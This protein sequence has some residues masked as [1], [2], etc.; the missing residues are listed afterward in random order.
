MTSLGLEGFNSALRGAEPRGVGLVVPFPDVIFFRTVSLGSCTLFPRA[1]CCDSWPTCRATVYGDFWKNFLS[2]GPEVDSP[3]AL[4]KL[5]LFFEEPLVSCPRCVR[6]EAFGVTSMHF[7]SDGE[8][9]SSGR[10]YH[11]VPWKVFIWRWRQVGFAG[12]R[13]RSSHR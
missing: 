5:E 4:G 9:E 1:R 3:V 7:L 8:L 10:F 11:G 13:E 6:I 2:M 12:C